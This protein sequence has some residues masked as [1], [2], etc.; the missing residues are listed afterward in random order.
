MIQYRLTKGSPMKLR[1]IVKGLLLCLVLIL[2]LLP[3][4]S[5]WSQTKESQKVYKIAILPFLIH[6]QE[7]LDYLRDGIYNIL[8][9]RLSVEGRMIVIDQSLVERALYE[10]RPMRLDE[11]VAAKIGMRA[12]ADYI[13]LGSLTKVGDY[14]SLDARVISVT[15]DKPPLGVFAQTKGIDDVM[16]KI[17]DFAQDIGYKIL[18]RQAT[19]GRSGPGGIRKQDV[20]RGIYKIDRTA[21]KRSQ[22][23][24]FEVRGLGIGD[25][26]GD[27]KNEL[28]IIDPRT[29]HVFRYDGE[30]LT[31]FQKMEAPY[32]YEFLSLDVADVNRNGRAEII[33]TAVI[34]DEI[35]SLILEYEEGKFRKVSDR[36]EWFLR[37]INHPKDGPILLGQQRDS[38]GL[39]SGYIYRMVWKKDSFERG[40]R[41]PFPPETMV[42]S[43]GMGNIRG[44]GKTDLLFLTSSGYLNM[45]SEDGKVVWK[46]GERFGGTTTFY[47]TQKKKYD[48]YRTPITVPYRVFI[49]G[50]IIVKKATGEEYSEVIINRNEF[51]ASISERARIIDKAMVYGLFWNE[52]RLSTDWE[53]MEIRGYIADYQVKDVA[54]T[55]EEDL[56]VAV[57]LPAEGGVSGMFTKKIES[58]I[59]FFKLNY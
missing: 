44:T 3:S 17:G 46:G 45:C 8:A 13:V 47:D 11:A 30:K 50:R 16:A 29:L 56:V 39:P 58:V 28:V 57:V 18:G 42:F 22:I 34:N 19:P 21:V 7:N 49:P 33:V 4:A 2:L 35:R 1:S 26:D 20:R 10:E 43:V 55:G 5:I 15:E 51:S 48:V 31:L 27:G 53:S 54:N 38:E 36:S 25:V 37:V 32:Q 41:M 6:S 9:S 59:Q 40:P 52:N 14:I 24:Q 23:L 12:G